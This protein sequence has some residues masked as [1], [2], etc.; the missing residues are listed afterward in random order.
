MKRFS[1]Y[2]KHDFAKTAF[3]VFAAVLL[4]ALYSVNSAKFRLINT[5]KVKANS[6]SADKFGN[7]YT[8]SNNKI[9]KFGSDGKY[10]FPYEEFRYGKIGMLDVTNP[11]KLLVFYPDFLTVVSLDRFLSPL[12]T[13]NFFSLGYQNIAAIASSVDGRL[14]FYDNV[15]FKLKKIDETGIIFRESQP[16]N[17]LLGQA[18]NPNFII[19]RDNQVYVNDSALGILVFD[20]FGSYNKTI[21]LRGLTKF[22]LVQQQIVYQEHNR[23]KSYNPVSFEWKEVQLPDTADLVQAVLEKES[24]AILKKEQVDF[25]RY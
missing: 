10:L 13:Y 14:W 24:L 25:Y 22:Q 21:P 6:V 16:L 19:E 20:F 8:A 15:D 2:L 3:A 17:V 23:L 18:P 1:G 11:M 9:L 5:Y 12:S 7:F 4:C